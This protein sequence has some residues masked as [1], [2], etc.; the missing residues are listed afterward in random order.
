MSLDYIVR[1][2][3]ENPQRKHGPLNLE[4]MQEIV[5]GTVQKIVGA[6]MDLPDDIDIYCNEDSKMLGMLPSLKLEFEGIDSDMVEKPMIEIVCG[7]IFIGA[8]NWE[9]G[10]MRSM[11]GE[12]LELVEKLLKDRLITL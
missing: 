8:A 2:P 5:H 11:T 7:P 4:V 3:L 12:E 9:T 10:D 1:N 6:V